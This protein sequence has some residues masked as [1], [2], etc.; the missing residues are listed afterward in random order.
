MSEGHNE[1]CYYC[2]EP[3]NSLAGDPGKW[4]VGLCHSDEP[5]VV[6]YH[7]E[8]CVNDRLESVARLTERC[9]AYKEALT[10]IERGEL[11]KGWVYEEGCIPIN[12]AHF[13]ARNIARAAL[14]KDKTA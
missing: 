8:A 7:H 6:K 11:P 4:P 9:D 3:C 10:R 13:H 2:G 14:A 12:D 1:P 5:G